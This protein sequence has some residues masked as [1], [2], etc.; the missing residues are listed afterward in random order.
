MILIGLME[1]QGQE[2]AETPDQ[3][4]HHQEMLE[5]KSEGQQKNKR[6]EQDRTPSDGGFSNE[7]SQLHADQKSLGLE[8]QL[9]P[10]RS[11]QQLS[12]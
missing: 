1:G 5:V 12:F 10:Q 7:T 4:M 8:P 9:F 3:P 11:S 2:M 6:V